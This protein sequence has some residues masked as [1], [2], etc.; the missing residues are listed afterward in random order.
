MTAPPTTPLDTALEAVRSTLV[1]TATSPAALA[2][3]NVQPASVKVTAVAAE[4][5][6]P[7]TDNTMDVR[8]ASAVSESC[9]MKTRWQWEWR[10]AKRSPTGSSA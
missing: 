1:C 4:S 7:V 3:P 9:L 2:G 8:R 6:L 10:K 5:G